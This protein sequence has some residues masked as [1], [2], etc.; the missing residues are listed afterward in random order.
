M[1]Y[2]QHLQM[3]IIINFGSE[4]TPLEVLRFKYVGAFRINFHWDRIY[5]MID[6]TNINILLHICYRIHLTNNHNGITFEITY[7]LKF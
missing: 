7:W 3:Q 5:N 4:I 6:H 2:I 1:Y